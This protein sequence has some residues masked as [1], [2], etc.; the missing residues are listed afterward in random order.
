MRTKCLSLLL[1]RF[2][3]VFGFVY[4]WGGFVYIYFAILGYFWDDILKVFIVL[5]S[6]FVWLRI[7][8]LVTGGSLRVIFLDN[9]DSF[10]QYLF[11]NTFLSIHFYHILQKNNQHEN[12]AKTNLTSRGSVWSKNWSRVTR[13]AEALNHIR[14]L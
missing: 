10:L 3:Y 9:F 11:S 8:S 7:F 5:Y 12:I 13:M 14:F 6:S 2:N 1:L 4:I